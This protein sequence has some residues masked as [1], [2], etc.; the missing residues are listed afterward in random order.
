MLAETGESGVY[1]NSDV[2]NLPI[3]GEDVDY[4]GDLTPIIKEWTSVYAATE[5]V[6]ATARL[7]QIRHLHVF[8]S[9]IPGAS[10][11]FGLNRARLAHFDR[12]SREGTG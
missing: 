5:D 2:L 9:S 8:E 10:P 11:L 12:N 1:C 3:P 7:E 6:H 4:D